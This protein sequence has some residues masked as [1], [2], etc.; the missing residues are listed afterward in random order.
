LRASR[1]IIQSN[2]ARYSSSSLEENTIVTFKDYRIVECS[3]V[4][5][6]EQVNKWIL[7]GYVLIGFSFTYRLPR[8]EW[9]LCQALAK[10]IEQK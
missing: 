10:P 3:G 5:L 2:A 7:E 4:E 8:G 6:S 1:R 9:M